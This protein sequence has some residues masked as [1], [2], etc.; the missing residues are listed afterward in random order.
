MNQRF[1]GTY[2]LHLPVRKSA[3]KETSL[4]QAARLNKTSAG[5]PVMYVREGKRKERFHW[6]AT[7]SSLGPQANQT[8]TGAW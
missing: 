2:H 7:V 5:I 8:E 4:Q 3:E 1:G 6:L